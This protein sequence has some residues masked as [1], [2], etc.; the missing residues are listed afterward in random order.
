M[1]FILKQG[2]CPDCCKDRFK[3][4]NTSGAYSAVDNLGGW[5]APNIVVGDV[6]ASDLYVTDPEGNTE[7]FELLD[8]PDSFEYISPGITLN[9]DGD[10]NTLTFSDGEWTFRWVMVADGDTYTQTT[11]VGSSCVVAACVGEKL[12]A[13]DPGCGCSGKKN[14]AAIIASLYLEGLK[15]AWACGKFEKARKLLERLQEMCSNNCKDC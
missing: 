14:D 15:A 5:G 11:I 13:V 8:L 1:A 12:A 6:T 7:Q 2:I 4:T 10:V 9:S 3:V